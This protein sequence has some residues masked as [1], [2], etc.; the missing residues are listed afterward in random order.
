MIGWLLDTHIVSALAS[1]S[2]A[3]SVK[4]WAST[5]HEQRMFVSVLTLAEIDKGIHNLEPDHPDRS[6]YAVARDAL[7]TRFADRILSVDDAVICRWGAISGEVK[8][9]TG[10]APSVIDTM[11]AATAVEHHLILVT[12]NAKDIRHSG[13]VIFDPWEDD[14]SLFPLT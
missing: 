13:A 14:P 5:Q 4:S 11:L 2:G 12:R 9:Q 8:R 6:R 3:P 1:P 10:H 7:A